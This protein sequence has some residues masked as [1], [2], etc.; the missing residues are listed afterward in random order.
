M[1][2]SNIFLNISNII[3]L[4]RN[5][6]IK[7]NILNELLLIFI[8]FTI[9]LISTSGCIT[10]DS[11]DWGNA[12]NINLND[13]YGE[14]FN[15]SDNLGNIILIDFMYVNC[16][17]C[18]LQMGELIKVYEEF[19]DKIVI[20]SISVFGAGDNNEDLITFKEY[21]K[22]N[23]IFA[24]DTLNEDATRKY[25]VLNVPKIFIINKLGDIEY[26]HT[27]YTNSDLIIDEINN[28][29]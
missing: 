15:L 24:L 4:R 10:N 20:I 27:G 11:G 9:I 28:I 13:I 19:E 1:L 12:P 17:P 22:A 2:T 25:N 16:P 6:L 7:K 18:Q 8:N 5:L 14:K 21:Y 26:T 23:W 3:K 29:I